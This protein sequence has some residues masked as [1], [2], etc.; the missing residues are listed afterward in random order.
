MIIV[1]QFMYDVI[2]VG[3]GVSGMFAA[4]FAFHRGK[5]VLILEKNDTLGKKILVT[6]NGR[7]NFTNDYMDAA[8]YES[9]SDSIKDS[10]VESV[11]SRFSNREFL[12]T[13]DKL[14]MSY[15]VREGYYYPRT[16]EAMTFRDT[17]INEINRL[18]IPVGS[19]TG[20][21]K[22]KFKISSKDGDANTEDKDKRRR[23]KGRLLYAY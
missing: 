22:L 18:K 9:S 20:A 21:R 4:I 10:F 16:D 13:M 19:D 15:Y 14:G 7:C 23:E 3:G 17:L 1:E 6:G 8:C 5:N 12:N 11:L 2:I